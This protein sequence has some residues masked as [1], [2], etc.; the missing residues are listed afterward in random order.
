MVVLLGKAVIQEG[1]IS[2]G[3]L[4][5]YITKYRQGIKEIGMTPES[6]A[7]SYHVAILVDPT[8]LRGF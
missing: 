8:A 2:A 5:D 4:E 1:A 3:R 6:F 7:S